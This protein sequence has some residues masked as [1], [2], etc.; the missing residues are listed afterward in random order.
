VWCEHGIQPWR[1]ETFKFST[2]PKLVATVTD[3]IGLLLDPRAPRG[4]DDLSRGE[5]PSPPGLSQ[6]KR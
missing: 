5:R 3:I 2:D 4:A 1:V 6:Q